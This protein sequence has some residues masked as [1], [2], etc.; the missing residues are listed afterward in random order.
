MRLLIAIAALLIVSAPARAQIIVD[1]QSAPPASE[2][3]LVSKVVVVVC[4]RVE[5]RT[6]E[7]DPGP[8]TSIYRVRIFELLKNDGRHKVGELIDVHRHGGFEARNADGAFPTFDINDDVVLFL[9]RGNNGW[10]WPLNGPDGAYKLT[11]D[12]R[13]HAYG[14]GAVAKRQHGRPV[15]EF[16]AEWRTFR[17]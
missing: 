16:L 2:A 4:G 8:A 10:Y 14:H 17:K 9:E 13:T 1:Y 3:T 7:S 6:M 5:A 15:A 11:A 12:G